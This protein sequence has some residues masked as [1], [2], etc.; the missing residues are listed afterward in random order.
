MRNFWT[1]FIVK[2]S[3]C[4]LQFE[5]PFRSFLFFSPFYDHKRH[6]CVCAGVCECVR[7]TLWR[8]INKGPLV[9]PHAYLLDCN[10]LVATKWATGGQQV[11]PS[12]RFTSLR[13]ASIPILILIL[14]LIPIPDSESASYSGCLDYVA[15]SI[16][17]SA[18]PRPPRLQSVN[19]I[20]EKEGR[21]KD[22]APGN[23][24][25]N[26]HLIWIDFLL[27]PNLIGFGNELWAQ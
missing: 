4:G 10:Q 13:F 2:I 12:L 14:I 8:P 5:F 20:E 3:F 21:R 19:Q 16:S 22:G 26:F 9:T 1:H 11:I 27:G 24:N 25:Y 6:V 23:F 7:V 15:K 17:L 18:T